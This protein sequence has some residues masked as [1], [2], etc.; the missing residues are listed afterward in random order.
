[1]SCSDDGYRERHNQNDKA[2][3]CWRGYP[4]FGFWKRNLFSC[5][6][7]KIYFAIYYGSFRIRVIVLAQQR[8]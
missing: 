7:W 1:M 3:D 8:S 2:Q 5:L 4:L 6:G